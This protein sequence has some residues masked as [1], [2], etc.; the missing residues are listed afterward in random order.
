MKWEIV[1]KTLSF[2]GYFRLFT[3]RVSHALFGGG[4]SPVITREL[5]QRGQAAAVLPYDPV[6]D[7]VV[8]IEQFRIGALD[9]P[10]GPWMVEVPAG[11]IEPGEGPEDVARREAMEEAGCEIGELVLAHQCY[12]SPGSCDERVAVY[13]G[14]TSTQGLGGVYGIREEGEDIRVRV[15]SADEALEM[16]RSGVVDS[17]MPLLAL[18]WLALNREALREAWA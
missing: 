4:M 7:E 13:V 18:Q 12:S 17:A 9:S 6:R 14:R 11:L 1:D 10:H 3:Y 8:L 5:L 15:V 2:Q 16:M